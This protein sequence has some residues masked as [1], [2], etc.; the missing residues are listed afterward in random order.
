MLAKSA[1]PIE[2]MMNETAQQNMENHPVIRTPY[3]HVDEVTCLAF[4]PTEQILA[5]G[6]RDYTL[7]LF[8]YSKPS[9]KRAF[10]YIQEAEMLRSISFHYLPETLSL[11]GLSI[12][13]FGFMI[14]THFN[15]LSLESSR[16]AHRC[17]MFC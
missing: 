13:L 17:H 14:S 3:D 11:L 15:V 5:S 10:K 4:H 1:M 7:K 16:S 9:A 12:L 2:V 6:S 8:D